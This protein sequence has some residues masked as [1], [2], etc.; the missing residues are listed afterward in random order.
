VST[1]IAWRSAHALRKLGVDLRGHANL[2]ANDATGES[3][4]EESSDLEPADAEL[5]RDFELGP[6]VEVEATGDRSKTD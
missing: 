3:L 4:F 6:T 5:L 1:T 2:D